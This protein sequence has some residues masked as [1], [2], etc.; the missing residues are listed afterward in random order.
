MHRRRGGPGARREVSSSARVESGG[1]QGASE[2][3]RGRELAWFGPASTVNA[4][5]MEQLCLAKQSQGRERAEHYAELAKGEGNVPSIEA[6]L[7]TL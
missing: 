4:E 7:Y 3:V 5:A 1:R 6:E 2:R